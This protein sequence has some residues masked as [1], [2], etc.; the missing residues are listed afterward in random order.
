[1]RV[2]N[3]VA[4][5]VD[6]E[7]LRKGVFEKT[8]KQH[9]YRFNYNENPQQILDFCNFCVFCNC[10]N[11]KT[12]INKI[13]SQSL[14]RI[15]I[16]T[17]KPLKEHKSF[18][19]INNLFRELERLNYIAMRY[20]K[21]VKRD[22]VIVQKQVDMLIGLDIAEISL[23][24][25]VNKIMLIGYDSDMSPALKLARISGIQTGIILFED[26]KP[27]LEQSLYKHCD[28]VKKIKVYDVYK[29]LGIIE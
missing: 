9:K 1:M 3:D 16:Y 22:E 13:V 7:N 29:H 20:G 5:F 15:F 26:I 10:D 12:N 17:A 24:N 4:I 18:D 28:I 25:I 21:L 2:C 23:K 19:K 8:A 6:F 14:Y 27:S 11:D